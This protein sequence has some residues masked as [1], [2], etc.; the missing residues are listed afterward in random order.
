MG[1]KKKT[2]A[3]VRG[4]NTPHVV[5]GV[6]N[7]YGR[8]RHRVECRRRAVRWT[9]GVGNEEWAKT[10]EGGTARNI[11]A[12]HG[13][14]CVHLMRKVKARAWRAEDVVV[15]SKERTRTAFD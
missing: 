8:S 9:N 1:T 11:V 13:S 14:A 5:Y 15:F 12:L 2:K 3:D 10:G 6:L 7:R 4:R